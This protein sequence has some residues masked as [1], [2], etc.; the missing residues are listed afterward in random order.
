MKNKEKKL[1]SNLT[2]L[3]IEQM[4]RRAESSKSESDT[5]Y[6]YDLMILGELV[7][8]FATLFLV[9]NIEDDVDR[10][11]YRFEYRLVRADGVGEYSDIITEIAIGSAA[12]FLPR[13]VRD[14]EVVELNS[15]M[16]DGSWQQNAVQ[17][18][19]KCL[20]VLNIQGNTLSKKS[21]L[22]IWFS[23]FIQVSQVN[24]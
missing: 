6:F 1:C 13:C 8:K 3:P 23:N 4:L 21:S 14:C 5:A 16:N 2:F 17:N 24:K 9:A 11:R 18:L 15:K 10:T 7:T 12:N 19:N 20:E 22:R